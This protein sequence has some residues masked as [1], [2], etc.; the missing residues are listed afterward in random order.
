MGKRKVDRF[1]LNRAVSTRCGELGLVV[2]VNETH[3]AYH[4]IVNGRLFDCPDSR[5]DPAVGC[6]I[7][8]GILTISDAYFLNEREVTQNREWGTLPPL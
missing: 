7:C 8:R 6:V 4:R 1:V 5:C 2:R 3:I